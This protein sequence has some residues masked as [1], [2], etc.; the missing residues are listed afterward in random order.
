MPTN[1]IQEFFRNSPGRRFA[2]LG[3]LTMAYISAPLMHLGVSR[4]QIGFILEVLQHEGICQ[5]E[6]SGLLY[7]DRAATARVLYELE[8]EGLVTR[9]PDARDRRKKRIYPTDKCRALE[10]GLLA[11]LQKNNDALFRGLPSDEKKQFLE[12]MDKLIDNLRSAINE[13]A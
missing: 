10:P 4:G 7:I 12:T 13:E 1:N 9:K 8:K 11:V 2:I 5:E 6:L 3:R